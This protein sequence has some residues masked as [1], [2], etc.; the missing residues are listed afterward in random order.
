MAITIDYYKDTLRK[1]TE[2]GDWSFLTPEFIQG[3]TLITSDVISYLSGRL[4]KVE[5]SYEEM[6]ELA[7]LIIRLANIIYHN[8]GDAPS[9][10]DDGIF[11]ELVYVYNKVSGKYIF[12]APNKKSS[13]DVKHKYPQLKGTLEKVRYIFKD[14]AEAAGKV[15]D[16]L[17]EFLERVFDTSQHHVNI[18]CVFSLKYDGIS[19]VVDMHDNK[20]SQILTR[21]DNEMGADITATFKDYKFPM[22]KE[23][24]KFMENS[25][26]GVQ[27]EAVFKKNKLEEYNKK[28]N[29][30]YIN[31]RSAM[32]GISSSFDTGED[33]KDYITLI[34]INLSE[35]PTGC[36]DRKDEL[37]SINRNLDM[38]TE[39]VYCS[40][41]DVEEVLN[42][43]TL[44]RDLFLEDRDNYP[45]MVDGIVVEFVNPLVRGELGRVNNINK[46]AIAYK[47]ASQIKNSTVEGVSFSV[48]RTGEVVPKVHYTPVYF[49]GT[50]CK[51]TTLSNMV[52]FINMGLKIG[53][54]ITVQYSNDVLCHVTKS[55]ALPQNVANKNPLIKYPTECPS[56]GE[57]LK[58][59][60]DHGMKVY[61]VNRECPARTVENIINFITKLN[62]K[63]IGDA[64]IEDMY[65][66]GHV[67]SIPDLLKFDAEVLLGVDGY[68]PKKIETIN[69]AL[70]KLRTKKYYDY[71]ILGA[72]GARS[73]ALATFK[74]L[75]A[76]IDF[77]DCLDN[78]RFPYSI[79]MDIA[80]IRG[81]G[82]IK[83]NTIYNELAAILFS[84]PELVEAIDKL[85]IFYTYQQGL[86]RVG[87]S[88]RVKVC[89]S[90]IR[91]NKLELEIYRLGGEVTDSITKDTNILVVKD[92]TV[93]TGKTTKAKKYGIEIVSHGVMKTDVARIMEKHLLQ[94]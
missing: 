26:Y 77:K 1:L 21:G 65:K 27:C 82:E 94:K 31:G 44:F 45:Y 16:S 60:A 61:C 74:K 80:S 17:E 90:G 62:I 36:K 88:D 13:V 57:P 72:I 71:E 51:K 79:K 20:V 85:N 78:V 47:F 64:T 11:D 12:S 22:L 53:D 76:E 7:E 24:V 46:F 15:G 3:T 14:E 6:N 93:N 9:L 75:C 86:G 92:A 2:D 54:I 4:T 87:E 73:A 23:N 89:F 5:L 59:I 34:P 49:N 25:D 41:Y 84:K 39:W 8:Y 69:E 68:G 55:K 67:K 29:K 35:R 50:E 42:K 30:K 81:F 63:N 66:L 33:L 43:F 10:L 91:D 37:E 40:G 83:A 19:A 18:E 28:Y 58:F 48:G 52:N 38:S 32:V 70:F 56:C